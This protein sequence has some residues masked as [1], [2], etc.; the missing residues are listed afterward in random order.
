MTGEPAP[1]PA[2]RV[3]FTGPAQAMM[4]SLLG[5]GA[6]LVLGELAAYV[7]ED[8]LGWKLAMSPE[9]AGDARR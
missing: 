9:L 4:L 6:G 1:V 7:S 5:G 3:E 8:K 2:V